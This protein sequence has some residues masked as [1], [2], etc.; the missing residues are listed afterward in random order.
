[1]NAG[2]KPTTVRL[3][4]TGSMVPTMADLLLTDDVPPLPMTASGGLHRVW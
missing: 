2:S 4:P 3:L 1:M